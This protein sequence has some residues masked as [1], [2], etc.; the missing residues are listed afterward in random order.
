MVS[1]A[2]GDARPLV[3]PWFLMRDGNSLTIAVAPPLDGRDA[4]CLLETGHRRRRHGRRR[5]RHRGSG[6]ATGALHLHDHRVAGHPQRRVV[7]S[8]RGDLTFAAAA[9][10][11]RLPGFPL[12][13]LRSVGVGGRPITITRHPVP[14]SRPDLQPIPQTQYA[15]IGSPEGGPSG[16]DSASRPFLLGAQ[17]IAAAHFPPGQPG[18]SF[19]YPRH[20]DSGEPRWALPGNG[21]G[22]ASASLVEGDGGNPTRRVPSVGGGPHASSPGTRGR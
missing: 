22:V 9:G 16:R 20:R 11:A 5:R 14:E 17:M 21:G 12:R 15:P 19:L 8:S 1:S 10:R 7:G 6:H 13:R 18:G 3:M 2:S 4:D